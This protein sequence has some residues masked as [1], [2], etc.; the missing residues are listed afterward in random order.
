VKD[1]NIRAEA[2][3]TGFR[4][5]LATRFKIGDTEIVGVLSVCNKPADAYIALRLGEIS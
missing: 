3:P 5:Q 4:A 1:F 2:D